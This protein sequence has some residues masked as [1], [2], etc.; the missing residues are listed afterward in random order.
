MR[1]QSDEL[2]PVG[3]QLALEVLLPG[4]EAIELLARVVRVGILPPTVPALCDVAL[5][6]VDVPDDAMDRLAERLRDPRLWASEP[7]VDEEHRGEVRR[8]EHQ[9]QKERLLQ[10]PARARLARGPNGDDHIREQNGD[11]DE[12]LHRRCS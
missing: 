5:Q 4:E 6:F 7:G 1:V 2:V 8:L 3:A 10:P 12:L 9:H 11:Q